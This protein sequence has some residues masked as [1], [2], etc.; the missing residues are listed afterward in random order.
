MPRYEVH[1]GNGNN[2]QARYYGLAEALYDAKRLGLYRNLRTSV[3]A[4]EYNKKPELEAIFEPS[5]S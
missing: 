2:L 1:I 5:I 4:V 3:W